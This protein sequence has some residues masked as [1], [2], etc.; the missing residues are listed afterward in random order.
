MSVY[1]SMGLLEEEVAEE[2][3]RMQIG[4]DMDHVEGEVAEGN[5]STD[6]NRPKP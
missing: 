1:K 5:D 3:R 4:V 6:E 2:Q